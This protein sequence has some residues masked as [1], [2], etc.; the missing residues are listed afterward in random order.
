MSD[1]RRNP[2]EEG[3]PQ[4]LSD[5]IRAARERY[6]PADLQH[7]S[8]NEAMRRLAAGEGL[9]TEVLAGDERSRDTALDLLAADALVT[10]AF[11]RLAATP[12]ALED[13][14]AEAVRRIASLALPAQPPGRGS[15]GS[16]D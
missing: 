8:D 4:A 13:R 2:E 14:A 16:G 11:E 6:S 10:E 7:A 9:L 5:R 12:E 15:A 1:E 3:L